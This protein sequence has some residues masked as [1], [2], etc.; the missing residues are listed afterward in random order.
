MEEGS[1]GLPT[2]GTKIR[3][4]WVSEEWKKKAKIRKYIRILTDWLYFL[5][6]KIGSGGLPSTQS[7]VLLRFGISGG[8]PKNGRPKIR[9]VSFRRTGTKICSVS[10]ESFRR[11]EKPKDF[12]SGGLPSC[13]EDLGVSSIF[14]RTEKTKIR[15]GW[16]SEEQ[17]TQRFVRTVLGGFP[18]NGRL[19]PGSVLKVQDAIGLLFRRFILEID[20]Y[21]FNILYRFKIA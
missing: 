1:G 10:R 3:L 6:T 21:L 18:K 12:I 4:R 16:A 2:N 5:D 8:F 11:T 7:F 14:R 20:F 19:D 17:K 15:F 13:E 9:S